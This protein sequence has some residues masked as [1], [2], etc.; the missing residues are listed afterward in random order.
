MNKV[1]IEDVIDFFVDHMGIEDIVM[2]LEDD[3]VDTFY[4]VN[5]I[6]NKLYDWMEGYDD[7]IYESLRRAYDEYID[8]QNLIAEDMEEGRLIQGE[9]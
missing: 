3:T 5:I 6:E 1:K 4:S 9:Y 8:Y 2:C 7:Y